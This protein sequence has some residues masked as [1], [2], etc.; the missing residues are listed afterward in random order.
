M[1]CRWVGF[2]FYSVSRYFD[3]Y[4]TMLFIMAVMMFNC[5]SWCSSGFFIYVPH[6]VSVMP[7]LVPHIT[8]QPP[9]QGKHLLPGFVV[10]KLVLKVIVIKI[11][12]CILYLRTSGKS[13]FLHVLMWAVANLYFEMKLKIGL[14]IISNVIRVKL[15]HK[16][17]II[18]KSDHFCSFWRYFVWE[19]STSKLLL[20]I[21]HF[22]SHASFDITY[23]VITFLKFSSR[24]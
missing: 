12:W 20:F 1:P 23:P 4:V 8:G 16:K 17:T 22:K 19:F 21:N 24:I 3:P 6:F 9:I 14:W 7:G 10:K 5:L 15:T 13:W 2:S 18:L 11:F